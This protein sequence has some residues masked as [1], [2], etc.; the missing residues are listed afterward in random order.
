MKTSFHRKSLFIASLTSSC[1]IAPHCSISS[2]T[3]YQV[4]IKATRGGWNVMWDQLGV[5][6]HDG[7]L[8][9]SIRLDLHLQLEAPKR[10]SNS[11][12]VKIIHFDLKRHA[13]WTMG[14]KNGVK[15][16]CSAISWVFSR[17]VSSILLLDLILI[18][19][20]RPEKDPRIVHSACWRGV[21]L[22][23]C[24]TQWSQRHHILPLRYQDVPRHLISICF[25]C[26]G[27]DGHPCV[28]FQILKSTILD[29]AIWRARKLKYSAM[30]RFQR[31]S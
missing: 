25:S 31:Q 18:V 1:P 11:T 30:G 14:W 28:Y 12:Y 23:R 10:Y 9:F 22:P 20:N 8:R 17:L 24:A 2:K 13:R 6:G 27:S 19:N 16:S 3:V 26:L 4:N 7:A 21:A 5:C 15:S 29:S